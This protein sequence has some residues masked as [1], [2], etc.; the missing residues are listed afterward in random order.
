MK[1]FFLLFLLITSCG[2]RLSLPAVEPS[3]SKAPQASL[4]SLPGTVWRGV[5]SDGGLVEVGFLLDGE[6]VYMKGASPD[7]EWH[8]MLRYRVIQASSLSIFPRG[9][10]EIVQA[11]I[12]ASGDTLVIN[13]TCYSLVPKAVPDLAASIVEKGAVRQTQ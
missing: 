3:S 6:R 13:S 2:T 7:R 5:H 8:A 9:G 1:P 4:V 11:E 12:G 10:E